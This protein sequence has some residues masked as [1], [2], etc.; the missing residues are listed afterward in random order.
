MKKREKFAY[1][2]NKENK[3]ESFGIVTPAFSGVE[4]DVQVAARKLL[5]KN[6]EEFYIL[7]VVRQEPFG[8]LLSDVLSDDF[9]KNMASLKKVVKRYGL[10]SQN[11]ESSLPKDGNLFFSSNGQINRWRTQEEEARLYIV[12]EYAELCIKEP[13]LYSFGQFQQLLGILGEDVWH[14]RTLGFFA[15]IETTCAG[16]YFFNA[17]DFRE[18]HCYKHTCSNSYNLSMLEECLKRTLLGM[19]REWNLPGATIEV[20]EFSSVTDLVLLSLFH[21]I[22]E[23]VTIKKCANCGRFFVPLTRSDAIYCDRPAPEDN[24]KTCKEYGSKVLWYENIVNDDV[25]KLAR[26]IYCSK[27]MLAKRNPDKREYADMFAFFK[28]EKK[29][30]EKEIKTGTKTR[31]EYAEWLRKMKLHKT[32]SELE[33]S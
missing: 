2:Y 16:S 32:L 26:N 6:V 14:L 28:T 15:P 23:R 10:S 11:G 4:D 17:G 13:Q 33:E 12:R 20:F 18:A 24:T 21:L 19:H 8:S 25:A 30:W 22:Q 9:S 5:P 31:E 1:F 3:M 7:K 27:Q 29:R